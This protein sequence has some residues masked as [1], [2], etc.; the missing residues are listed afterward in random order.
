MKF[1]E[2]LFSSKKFL[3]VVLRIRWK[4]ESR[5][6]TFLIQSAVIDGSNIVSRCWDYYPNCKIVF[7]SFIFPS[8]SE[9]DEEE[10]FRR[11]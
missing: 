11:K 1:Y 7:L 10:F 9:D 3:L 2:S 6:T 5:E 8:N 4:N